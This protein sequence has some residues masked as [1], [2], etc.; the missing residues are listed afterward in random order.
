M[1]EPSV[2]REKIR[3]KVQFIQDC[4]TRLRDI[5]A[6]GRDTFLA[7]TLAQAAAVR[8]LQVGIEAM[9]DAANH[10]VARGGLGIPGT[11]RE[12]IEMLVDHQVLPAERRTAFVRMVGFRNRAVHLYEDIAPGEVFDILES[13][14]GDFEAFMAAI[15][16]KYL[17]PQAHGR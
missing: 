16:A 14:L 17:A 15:V 2:D 4:L 7:D 1:R 3:R 10:I 5:R 11:Y 8:L 9:L 13:G 6:R 12:S